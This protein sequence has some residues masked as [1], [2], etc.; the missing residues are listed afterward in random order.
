MHGQQNIKIT[1]LSVKIHV[2]CD[3]DSE[4]DC[5]PEEEQVFC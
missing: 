5:F 2:F 3:V 1:S 4:R